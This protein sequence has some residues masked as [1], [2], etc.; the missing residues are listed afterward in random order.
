MAFVETRRVRHV[1][2]LGD[3]PETVEGFLAALGGPAFLRVPGV[4]RSRTRAVATLLHG[5]E[6]SGV[7]AVHAWLRSGPAPAPAVDVVVFLGAVEAA[8]AG[9]GFR[10]RALP[11]GR[12]LNR[13]FGPLCDAKEGG[14]AREALALLRGAEPEALVDLHNTSGATPAYGLGPD[15]VPALL[16][17]GGLF[18][19]RYV[20]TGALGLGALVEAAGE[21]APSVVVECGQRGSPEAD[22]VAREGLARFA[23]GERAPVDGSLVLYRDPVRVELASGAAVAFAD[24]PV[25]G[26]DLTLRGDV[27]RWNLCTLPPGTEL[28]WVRPGAPWPVQ[29]RRKGG[30]DASRSLFRVE[31]E[32]LLTRGSFTPLMMTTDP[33]SARGDCLCYGVTP[34]GREAGTEGESGARPP[35]GVASRP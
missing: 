9:S 34:V 25:P 27:D 21:H 12:D 4:D 16:E 32:R 7:R 23:A 30:G 2:I 29:A 1:D 33:E 13:C 5:D 15:A 31:G 3:V 6:P 19:G 28:G 11:G 14:T 22:R 24:A 35:G 18:A 20:C 10:H 17:I 26:A 8:L